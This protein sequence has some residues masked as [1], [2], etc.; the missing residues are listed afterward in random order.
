MSTPSPSATPTHEA[1]KRRREWELECGWSDP[2]NQTDA[3]C[4]LIEQ[5]EVSRDEVTGRLLV[6]WYSVLVEVA[7]QDGG[8]RQ[9]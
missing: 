8:G 2:A 1:A 9:A 4:D 5:G 3:C 6:C 7:V